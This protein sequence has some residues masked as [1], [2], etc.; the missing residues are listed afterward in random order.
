M[1]NIIL[2]LHRAYSPKPSSG[3][4]SLLFL[5]THCTLEECEEQGKEYEK[6][7]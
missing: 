4:H 6:Q 2:A 3:R 5:G 7:K 1:S